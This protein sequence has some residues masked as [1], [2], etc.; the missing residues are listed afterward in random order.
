MMRGFAIPF[1]IKYSKSES[2]RQ[3][4]DW[5]PIIAYKST[6]EFSRLVGSF[7]VE[8]INK[9]NTGFV[10]SLLPLFEYCRIKF[11]FEHNR[12]C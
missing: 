12:V 3:M 5:K 7:S 2:V 8:Q 11:I 6:F 10:A 1:R 4:F 9:I